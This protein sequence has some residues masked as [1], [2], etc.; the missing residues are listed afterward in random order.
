LASAAAAQ[1]GLRQVIRL[2]ALVP[3]AD[4][5]VDSPMESRMRWR[6]LEAGFPS[7]DLQV[8]VP[9]GGASRWMDIGW[10]EQR[11]GAEFD[12]QEAHMTPQQL[13]NDRHRHN[14]L[15]ANLWTL[16]HFTSYDVYRAHRQMLAV[17]ARALRLPPDSWRS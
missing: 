16:L 4:P 7:P 1:A 15:T 6:F 17:T 14:W 5:R 2:R 8:E 11:V 12:G 10:H 3:H 13:R 9:V